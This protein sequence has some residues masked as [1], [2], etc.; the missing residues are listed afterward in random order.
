MRDMDLISY[1]SG[2]LNRLKV[3]MVFRSNFEILMKWN[4]IEWNEK[5]VKESMFQLEI[6]KFG[7]LY[8][9]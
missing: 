4:L 2:V 3:H 6:W 1:S 7:S 5:R 9:F 8:F